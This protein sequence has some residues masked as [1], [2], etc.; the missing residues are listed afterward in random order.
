MRR[1]K[2][3]SGSG[4]LRVVFDTNVYFSAFRNPEG[5][6]ARIFRA[7]AEHQYQIILS[8]EIIYEYASACREKLQT[9]E[10]KIQEDIKVIVRAATDIVQPSALFDAVPDDPDDNHIL[11]C[12]LAGKADLIVSGDKDLLRLKEYEGIAIIRPMDFLRTIGE[13]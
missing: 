1:D 4:G 5:V 12:A 11:A 7:G 2:N 10:E 3:D 9:R 6:A 13:E 8:P